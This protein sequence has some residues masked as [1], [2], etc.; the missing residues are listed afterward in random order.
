MVVGNDS[1]FVLR[2]VHYL[3]DTGIFNFIARLIDLTRYVSHATVVC[4]PVQAPF[5]KYSQKELKTTCIESRKTSW[6]NSREESLDLHL[7][8]QTDHADSNRRPLVLC[9]R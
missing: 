5:R 6:T 2:I 4:A 9:A 3:I 1:N 7:I 8:G